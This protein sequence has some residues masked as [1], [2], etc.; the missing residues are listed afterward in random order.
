MAATNILGSGGISLHFISAG[1]ILFPRIIFHFRGEYFLSRGIFVF[2]RRY[3][4]VLR[5]PGRDIE[6]IFFFPRGI[7]SGPRGIF[8]PRGIF[9]GPRGI[10]SGP[11]GIFFPRGIFSG[12]R[13]IIS[14]PRGIFFRGEYFL[15]RGE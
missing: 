9:S 15:G 4:T 13:G 7:F 3:C 8:F 1:N 6:N 5:K 14:G 2:M 11:R 12:P 10:F